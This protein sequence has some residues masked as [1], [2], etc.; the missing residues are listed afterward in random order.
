MRVSVKEARAAL[1]QYYKDNIDYMRGASESYMRHLMTTFSSHVR[2]QKEEGRSPNHLDVFAFANMLCIDICIILKNGSVCF[3]ANAKE[4]SCDIYI[5]YHGAG[6]YFLTTKKV[7]TRSFTVQQNDPSQGLR[8]TE[9]V[10]R[11]RESRKVDVMEMQDILD[12]WNMDVFVVSENF[13]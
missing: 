6:I 10:E 13:W 8:H 3:P 1:H 7:T 9:L 12:K 4:E 2:Y 5:V 11:F